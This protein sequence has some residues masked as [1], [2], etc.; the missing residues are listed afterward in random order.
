MHS[1]LSARSC[2]VIGA[3]GIGK[4]DFLR[5]LL[6]EPVRD[7]YLAERSPQMAFLLIDSH[8]LA[9][10]SALAYYRRMTAGLEQI[11]L[12]YGL[13]P[14]TAPHLSRV[15]EEEAILVLFE[16]VK[17]LLLFQDL[18]Q[19][20]FAF[21][22]FTVAFTEVEQHFLRVLHAL[23]ASYSGRI[24]YVVTS[25]NVPALLCDP[26]QQKIVYQ[27]F[28]ELFNG[29][30][31]GLKP[32]VESDAFSQMD[33]WLAQEHT[34]LPLSL[35]KLCFQATGG[36]PGLLKTTVLAMADG[37]LS[38]R[39]QDSLEALLE[40]SLLHASVLS[41][42]ELLWQSFSETEHY[43]LRTLRH[44]ILQR[45]WLMS[46]LSPSLLREA[47][48]MLM[49]KGIL[50][51]VK[52][53]TTFQCFSPLFAAFVARQGVPGLQL[54][55]VRQQVWIDGVLQTKRLTVREFKLLRFLASHAGDICSRE[56]TTWAVY[57]EE[58][59]AK[60]DAARLDA[61]VERARKSIGDTSRPPRFLETVRGTGHRLNAYVGERF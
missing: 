16:R 54:D 7:H 52:S 46:P 32:L 4:T 43:C 30:V 45:N 27:M 21:D 38:L 53:D 10:P 42:C 29:Y 3:D 13:T 33:L 58:Y 11:L 41:Q 51:E 59:V 23:R 57:G 1:L 37:S 36:H 28:A 48:R 14:A 15:D 55:L 17:A 6:S 35:R 61:L 9:Q 8:A 49:L 47:L 56:E 34:G 50:H 25:R 18:L 44:G 24:S 20:V 2:A 60:D 19:L 22:E 40:Q 5:H 26:V 12:Q 39:G 31:W